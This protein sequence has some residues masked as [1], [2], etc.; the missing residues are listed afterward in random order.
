MRDPAHICCS[1]CCSKK[2]A[3]HTCSCAH[4]GRTAARVHSRRTSRSKQQGANTAL[5]EAMRGSAAM[6]RIGRHRAGC[7]GHLHAV[8]ME[9]SACAMQ[10]ACGNSRKTRN[11][12]R[13]QPIAEV[14][15]PPLT[16]PAT[17]CTTTACKPCHMQCMWLCMCVK[18]CWSESGSLRW[19][20]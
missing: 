7:L 11:M 14:T 8:L 19:V 20:T 4:I 6:A 1:K 9:S 17:N 3:R 5:H 2:K 13:W 12:Q 15:V 18:D 10:N 16:G